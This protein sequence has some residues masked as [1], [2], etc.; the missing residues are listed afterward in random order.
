MSADVDCH[1]A[2]DDGGGFTNLPRGGSVR[3]SSWS[4]IFERRR[5]RWIGDGGSLPVAFVLVGHDLQVEQVGLLR[6]VEPV[7]QACNPSQVVEAVYHH[8][9]GGK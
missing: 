5:K 3:K 4:Q 8:P 1:N 9:A 6:A 7:S 2:V